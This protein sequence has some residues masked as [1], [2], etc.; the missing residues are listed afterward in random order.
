MGVRLI[1]GCASLTWVCI[2]HMGLHL[3]HGLTSL[4]WTYISHMGVH[5]SHGYTSLTWTYISHGRASLTW[6]YISHMGVHL[7]HGRASMHLTYGCASI[8]HMSV[9]L[10]GMCLIYRRT[11]H[12]GGTYIQAYSSHPMRDTSYMGAH[13]IGMGVHLRYGRAS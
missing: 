11:S 5:L 13:L 7:S 1:H 6:A 9:Q 2:S 3:S 10:I 12:T 4:T 8:P